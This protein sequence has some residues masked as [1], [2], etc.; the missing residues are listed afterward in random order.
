MLEIGNL[1]LGIN[2]LSELFKAA[3]FAGLIFQKIEPAIIPYIE[4]LREFEKK[5]NL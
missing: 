5:H 2:F 1:E 3:F 4:R